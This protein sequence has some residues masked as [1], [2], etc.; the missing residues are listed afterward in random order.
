MDADDVALPARLD[1]QA[2]YLDSEAHRPRL[3]RMRA[4][5]QGHAKSHQLIELSLREV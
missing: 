4:A 5:A 2:G 1:R 3:D